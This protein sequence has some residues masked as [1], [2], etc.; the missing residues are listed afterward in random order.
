M[1]FRETACPAMHIQIM[2]SRTDK[3][4]EKAGTLYSNLRH[5]NF[6]SHSNTV[7]GRKQKSLIIGVGASLRNQG[8]T[9]VP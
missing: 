1:G 2:L 5:R 3:Y 9:E 4:S 7:K 6:R 8:M